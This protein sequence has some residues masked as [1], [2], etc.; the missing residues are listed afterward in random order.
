MQ[1]ERGEIP[2]TSGKR[3]FG[4]PSALRLRRAVS[5]SKEDSFSNEL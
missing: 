1:E 3:I 4:V 5:V 2:T